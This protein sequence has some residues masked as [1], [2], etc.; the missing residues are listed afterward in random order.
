MSSL[1]HHYRAALVV[2][3]APLPELP[4][5]SRRSLPGSRHYF[6]GEVA[7]TESPNWRGTLGRHPG[8][9]NNPR[10]RPP[11][12]GGTLRAI[13]SPPLPFHVPGPGGVGRILEG[14]S[15]GSWV[16]LT[17][18]QD[19]APRYATGRPR[20]GACRHPPRVR[21][22]GAWIG[23]SFNTWR[24]ARADVHT[25]DGARSAWPVKE[26][27]LCAYEPSRHPLARSCR[28]S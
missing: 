15:A 8:H 17:W 22:R 16:L 28:G 3:T 5:L 27:T 18:L 6:Q 1:T 25:S 7:Q 21:G 23:F 20:R 9:R 24:C 2:K 11:A 10:D 13:T 26:T 12:S 4:I 14:S 19:P